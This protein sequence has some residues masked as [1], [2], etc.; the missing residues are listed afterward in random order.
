MMLSGDG[1]SVIQPIIERKDDVRFKKLKRTIDFCML[2][3][4]SNPD[5]RTIAKRRRPLC[6]SQ[7]R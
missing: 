2:Q 4:A 3:Y 7:Y 5:E 1:Y 6:G